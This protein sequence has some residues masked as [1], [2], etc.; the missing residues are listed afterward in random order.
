M[1][2]KEHQPRVLVV[3]NKPRPDW[4]KPL[5]KFDAMVAV[6]EIFKSDDDQHMFRVNGEHPVG[7]SEV[8]SLCRFDELM[9]RWLLV[10]SP[11]SLRVPNQG[12]L[13]IE[14]N[15]HTTVW[16]RHGVAGKVWL[17]TPH[18]PNPLPENFDYELVRR[19]DGRFA[20][21]KL[22]KQKAL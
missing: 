6:F 19:G 5:A 14:F 9:N 4:I 22:P 15:G 2:I 3:V 13:G 10:E 21:E 20:F 7:T 17:H 12:T 18:G 11:I 1:M 8:V 16:T